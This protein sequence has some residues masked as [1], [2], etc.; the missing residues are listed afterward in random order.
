MNILTVNIGG[1]SSKLGL[2]TLA[3]PNTDVLSCYET[4]LTAEE[5]YGLLHSFLENKA[6]SVGAIC[7]RIVH[8]GPFHTE[9]Q[10]ITA[11]VIAAIEEFSHI[12]PNHNPQA[13]AWIRAC[14]DFFK[15]SIPQ[16]AVFDTG[17]FS[18]LPEVASRYAVPAELSRPRLGFHGIAH[19]QMQEFVKGEQS[20]PYEN[21]RVISL[22]LGSGCSIAASVGGRPIDTSMGYTPLEG[23]MMATRAG[24]IDPGLLLHLMKEEQLRPEELEKILYEGSGLIGVSGESADMGELL[25]S[26]TPQANLAVDMFCYRIKK[27]IGAYMAA[28]GGVDWII[29]SGGIGEKAPTIRL[30][31]LQNLEQFGIA[32]DVDANAKAVKTT[33]EINLPDQPV[34]I[35]VLSCDENRLMAELTRQMQ[36]SPNKVTPRHF[37]AGNNH[38]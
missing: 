8:A 4:G 21:T 7:H 3:Q 12:A 27:Y 29:F 1:S 32:V 22:Q 19:Q 17:H 18:N 23:L 2:H 34:R 33:A 30:K 26:G 24:D 14:E 9:P 28:L 13:L 11:D 16:F 37:H 20:G 5:A 15:A 10:L 36:F 25:M 6:Q 38:G 31:V 35:A